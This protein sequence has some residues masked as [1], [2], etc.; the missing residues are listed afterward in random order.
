M[1]KLINDLIFHLNN[2]FDF[3]YIYDT[4]LGK[5]NK[6]FFLLVFPNNSFNEIKPSSATL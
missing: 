2:E 1:E 4:I 3:E 5:T 6:G